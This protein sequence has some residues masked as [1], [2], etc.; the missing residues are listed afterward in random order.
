MWIVDPDGALPI[1]IIELLIL[2]NTVS[3]WIVSVIIPFVGSLVK[4][5][6]PFAGGIWFILLFIFYITVSN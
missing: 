6:L 1:V 2:L 4:I 3:N 5:I